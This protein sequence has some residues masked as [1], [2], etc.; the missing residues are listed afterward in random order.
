MISGADSV[1]IAT[2]DSLFAHHD[3]FAL[4]A[5]VGGWHGPQT[6]DV[7]YFRGVLARSF[8]RPDDAITLLRPLVEGAPRTL[9]PLHRAIAAQA[10]AESYLSI[11][12]YR[13]AAV[14]YGRAP[15]RAGFASDSIG[16]LQRQSEAEATRRLADILPQRVTWNRAAILDTVPNGGQ[17]GRA[18][19]SLNGIGTAQPLQVDPG[20]AFTMIDST[21]AATHHLRLLNGRVTALSITGQKTTAGLGVMD[22]LGIGAASVSNVVTLV[23]GDAD[24]TG[25][26]GVHVTGI[27]GFPVI[28]ALRR[29][30]LT[31]DGHLALSSPGAARLDSMPRAPMVL[32]EASRKPFAPVVEGSYSG[33]PVSL[34]LSF[35]AAPTVLYPPFLGLMSPAARADTSTG[36][37][38]S[39]RAG[40]SYWLRDVDLTIGGDT[41]HF[42]TVRA[43]PDSASA[44]AAFHEGS[45]GTDAIRQ[46]DAL[47]FDFQTMTVAFDRLPPA[48]VL[49]SMTNPDQTTPVAPPERGPREL[50]FIAL[51]FALFIVPRALQRFRIPGAITSLVMGGVASA[52]G[53][54]SN[55]PTLQ[56]LATLGIV[57][58]FLFAGLEIDGRELQSNAAALLYHAAAWAALATATALVA[59]IGFGAAPRVAALLALALV[60]PS[61]GF[62]LSSLAGL[63]LAGP[64]Q[65]TVKT[66]AIASELMALAA[67]F[68]VL[69][70]TSIARLVLAIAAMIG[71]VILIPLA[72]RFFAAVVAPYA[73]RS[74]FAFLLMVAV[75]C[76]YTTRRLGVYYLVGAFVVGVAA[77]RFRADHPAM[78]SEKMVDALESFGS[79]FIPFYFFHA[80]TEIMRDQLTPKA[81]AIGVLLLVAVIPIRI[82]VV[83]FHRRVALRESFSSARRI[84]S[85]LVPTLVFTLVIVGILHDRFGMRSDIIGGLILYTVLNTIMPAFVLRGA[86]ADFE[87]VSATPVG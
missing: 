13:E 37:A 87:D 1:P 80:G 62:I 60:T 32:D 36:G 85:A 38:D 48:P 72:F 19:V 55:D 46:A 17:W 59:A 51:L 31:S 18:R 79:V 35:T 28:N 58:L 22:R 14:A 61:T 74:E 86:P 71:V 65:R 25:A 34:A 39:S 20:A 5:R 76:A 63:G 2:W 73:P 47:T 42:A 24:L 6:P 53:S 30:A 68:F 44:E 50:A 66:Y 10:L 40:E 83:G 12:R 11:Y 56:L 43:V 49:P 3:H 41:I 77:Q 7:Q 4:R 75:V 8:N 81:L 67:L 84:G 29:V 15:T 82:L 70:S 9:G 16:R 52:L 21:T 69:Q 33:H 23:L 57:A 64:E 27:I 45:L 78:S 54:F 26:D